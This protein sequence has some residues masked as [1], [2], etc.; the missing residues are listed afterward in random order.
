VR[1]GRREVGPTIVVGIAG[2][3][4]LAALGVPAGALL[5]SVGAVGAYSLLTDR[6]ARMPVPVRVVARIIMGTVIG[7]V[8]TRELLAELGMNVLWALLFTLVMLVVGAVAGLLLAWTTNIDHR[9]A[10]MSTCPGGMS[11]LALLSDELAVRT[12]VVLGVHLVRKVLTLASVALIL[13][14]GQVLR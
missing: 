5:G 8:L 4:A 7:S 14:G 12:E 6:A 13:V 3:L 9:T 1:Q 11:E 2:G 10:L